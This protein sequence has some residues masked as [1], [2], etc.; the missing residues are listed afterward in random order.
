M[1]PGSSNLWIFLPTFNS[2]DCLQETESKPKRHFS[3]A[4]TLG[5]IK[6]SVGG[7]LYH[8]WE[9]CN[10]KYLP[11]IMMITCSFSSKKTTTKKQKQKKPR[12]TRIPVVVVLRY[13][14]EKNNKKLS[15]STPGR[16]WN[17]PFP[18]IC[19]MDLSAEDQA[20]SSSS[21]PQ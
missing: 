18:L 10:S 2:L 17:A 15:I 19:P 13:E 21:V 20:V 7:R 14:V 1:N 12:K 9:I 11:W 8:K 4:V 6:H 16:K 3:R 5:C